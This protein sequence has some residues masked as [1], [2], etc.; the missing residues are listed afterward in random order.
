MISAEDLKQLENKADKII[1][2]AVA[3]AEN[4]TWEPVENLTKNVYRIE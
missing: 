4:G 3:D 2:Q 1:E